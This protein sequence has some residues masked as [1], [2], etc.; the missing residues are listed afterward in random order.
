MTEV[1]GGGPIPP[2]EIRRRAVAS[3][4]VVAARGVAIN[5]LAFFGNVALARLLV[6]SDYGAVALGLAVVTLASLLSDGGLGAGLIRRPEPPAADDLRALLTV[7]L[8]ATTALAVIAGALGIA[9]GG[10]AGVTAVMMAGLP[11]SALRGP[12]RVVLQRDID[13]RPVAAVEV[14]EVLAYYAAGI[15]MV[16]AGLGVWGLAAASIVK[17]VAGTAILLRLAPVLPPPLLSRAHIAGLLGFGLRFQAV[18]VVTSVR[19]Q[20]VQ[21]GTAAVAGTAVLGLWTVAWK[22]LQVP[23]LLYDALWRVSFPALSQ[24]VAA[25][26]D[27]RPVIE[28]MARLGATATGIMLTGLVSAAPALVPGLFGDAY[29]GAAAAVPIVGAALQVSGPVSVATAGWLFAVGRAGT[30]LRATMLQ[31]VLWFGIAF[32][33]LGP[34][35]VAAVGIGYFV[36]ALAESVIFTRTATATTGARFSGALAIPTV[37]AVAAA[38]GGWLLCEALGRTLWAAAVAGPAGMTAYVL[39]LA[40][41]RRSLLVE[42]AAFGRRALAGRGGPVDPATHP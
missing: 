24:L 10:V 9:L 29:A 14:G 34:V 20:G 4:T 35:G 19:D 26:E 1:A 12:A 2:N 11:V 33:L 25:G 40:A 6:P 22:L 38:A 32:P 39:L 42:L 23:F 15:G 8:V 5:V 16:A 41:A 18:Q 21:V 17:A 27:P 37:A 3:A 13:F 30:V 28:R 7:Q 31:V 36:A